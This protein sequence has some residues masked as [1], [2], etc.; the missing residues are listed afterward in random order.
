M[1]PNVCVRSAADRLCSGLLLT[2]L[3]TSGLLSAQAPNIQPATAYTVDITDLSQKFVDFYNAS[4]AEQADPDRR[5]ELWKSKYDF[6]AVPNI[7]AG[8]KMAREQLDAAWAKYPEAMSQIRLGAAAL[9]PSPQERLTK[10]AELLGAQGPIR[11]RLI[12]F[13]GTFRRSAFSMGVKDGVSTIA[14]PLEDSAQDHALDMTHEFT[15]AVQMHEGGWNSQSVASAVFAEGLA[16]R[17]TEHFNPGFPANI[18][19]TSSPAWFEKCKASLPQVLNEVGEHGADSGAQ[20]VSKFIYGTGTAGINREVYC[21]G[22]FVVKK[23][24]S[25]GISFSTLGRMTQ[26]EAEARVAATIDSLLTS[27]APAAKSNPR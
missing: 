9:A 1:E 16:M 19:T 23:M 8:Q 22:W 10:V 4:V 7:P 18:Y 26:A 25:D 11:I 13:V 3:I 15:H 6:S 17:V 21:G 2:L 5:W 12:A 27:S 24:L 14:I 20:A